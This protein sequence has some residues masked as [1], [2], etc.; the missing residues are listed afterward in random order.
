MTLENLIQ[1]IKRESENE[2]NS[3]IREAE[4]KARKIVEKGRNEGKNEANRIRNKAIKDAERTKEKILA[5]ARRKAKMEITN[6]KE[7][8]IQLC[9]ER[10]KEK[11]ANMDKK[12]YIKLVNGMAKKAIKEIKNGYIISTRKEDEEISKKLKMEIKEKK[13][14]IGGIIIKSKDGSKE[15]DLTFDFIIERKKDE[16]RISIAKKLFGEK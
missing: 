1:R 7:D 2:I 6:A 13:K 12:E 16:I 4:E 15:I 11:L 14:G 10:M 5:A 9:F 8:L 3:I